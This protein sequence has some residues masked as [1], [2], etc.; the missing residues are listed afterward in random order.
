ML[1][2]GLPGQLFEV[3]EMGLGE[4]GRDQDQEAMRLPGAA[5]LWRSMAIA[6]RALQLSRAPPHVSML[7]G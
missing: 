1:G 3:S 2:P 4:R 6:N 5:K 7:K